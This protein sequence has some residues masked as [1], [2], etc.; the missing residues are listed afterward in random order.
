MRILIV[1]DDRVIRNELRGALKA[2]GYAI[3][4]AADGERGA[5]LALCNEYDCIILDNRMPHKYGIEVVREIRAAEKGTPVLMISVMGSPMH[6]AK[7]LNAG[8]D[9]Y[10]AKPYSLEELRARIRALLRRP[11]TITNDILR[12][13]NLVLDTTCHQVRRGTK[14][15]P[16]TCKEFALLEYFLRN[17]GVVL[18]RGTLL[19]HVWDTHV[20]PLSNTIEAHIASL[21]RKIER[22]N[23]KPIIKTIR[24]K[25]YKI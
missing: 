13:D 11:R 17:I 20:N 8:A 10:L 9:D 24:G 12:V 23:L 21:R 14:E 6:K 3:D 15:I 2:D 18:S 19:E 25:G 16:L 22:R 7:L 4:C 5:Y 1:D